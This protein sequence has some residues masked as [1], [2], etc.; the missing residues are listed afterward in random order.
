MD[1]KRIAAEKAIGF[2]RDGMLLGLGTGSTA[3]WAIVGIAERIRKEKL[4]VR[5]IAT[6]LQSEKLARDS[7]ISIVPFDKNAVID[8]TID[9]ADEVNRDLDLIK[10][11]GGALLREKIVA[12][13]SRQLII[14]V[15]DSKLVAALG[16][17]PL[18]VEIATFGWELTAH[19][20]SSLGCQPKLR[21]HDGKTFVTDNGHYILDCN[22]EVISESAYLNQRI[23]EI[24][25]VMETGL[26]VQMASKVI[27]G[28]EDGRTETLEG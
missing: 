6:S 2:V 7:G 26:F 4:Q 8:L 12:Y 15:D 22:F 24:P 20:L 25:G 16:R 13:N 10:G 5:A 1:P 27:V 14:I 21:M 11:G 3:H 17:F 18:P 9:G 28:Y 19:H 23:R